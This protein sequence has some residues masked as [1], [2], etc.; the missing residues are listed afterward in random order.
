MKIKEALQQQYQ[1]DIPSDK[2]GEIAAYLKAKETAVELEGHLK[3]TDKRMAAS[4]LIFTL[5]MLAGFILSFQARWYNTFGILIFL[6][7]V[8]FA[9]LIRV[10]ERIRQRLEKQREWIELL[11][12]E[13]ACCRGNFKENGSGL[14]FLNTEHDY[15]LDLDLFGA[16]SLFSRI[17]RARSELVKQHFAHKL[18]S[19]IKEK[20]GLMLVRSQL[21]ALSQKPAFS[22]EFMLWGRVK[23]ASDYGRASLLKWTETTN[24]FILSNKWRW[25]LLFAPIISLTLL[26]LWLVGLISYSAPLICGIL[27]LLIC[28]AKAK[29]VSRVQ[30]EM[31]GKQ[32]KLSPYADLAAF[33]A[34]AG[35]DNDNFGHEVKQCKE[36]NE[37]I[38]LLKKE[39]DRLDARLNVPVM[40]LLNGLFLWDLQFLRRLELWKVNNAGQLE[41]WLKTLDDLQ[42][43][44]YMAHF[45]ATRSSYTYAEITDET[46]FKA[47]SLGHPFIDPGKRIDNDFELNQNATF[48][49]LTGANMAGKSTFLRSLGLAIC[50]TQIGL[51]VCAKE[52]SMPLIRL[53]TSMRIDDSLSDDAS[54]FYA[55]LKRLKRLVSAVEQESC[56]V[57]MDEVLRGTNTH[58]K[59]FGALGLLDRLLKGK[60]MGM[61]ATHDTSLAALSERDSRLILRSF[62]VEQD[63]EG[64]HFDYRLREGVAKNMNASW[65]M[66]SMGV[67]AGD[68]EVEE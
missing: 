22:F 1:L 27:Y 21:D 42:V 24:N 13:L 48:C 11:K 34:A 44:V 68:F 55:E 26:S 2:E 46:L 4:R 67:I 9:L 51:K 60:A 64:L 32:N 25:L 35:L 59:H 16:D 12:N 49:L 56:F 54:Y 30:A 41:S 37:E 61:L 28:G 58:D 52:I 62:E 40:I 38:K 50:M 10:H 47:K 39:V 20:A 23:D 33:V 18:L 7:I 17:N 43:R 8:G 66:K 3:N 45:Q 63:Q 36:A 5:A 53:I 6:F 19:P 65:L 29:T 57:L 14:E 31:G 15:A